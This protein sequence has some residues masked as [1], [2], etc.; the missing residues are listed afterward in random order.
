MPTGL[1]YAH[2]GLRYLVVLLVLLVL[3]AA[4]WGW[5]SKRQAGRLDRVLMSTLAATITVQALLGIGLV[6]TG[7]WYGA[8]GGHLLLMLIAVG[9]AHVA[10]ARARR[11]PDSQRAHLTRLIGAGLVLLLVFA[12]VQSIGRGL[13]EARPVSAGP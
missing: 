9:V 13:F 2:S 5:L 12:G 6:A 1:Y 4:A 11:A 7:I 10:A 8:L 3:A